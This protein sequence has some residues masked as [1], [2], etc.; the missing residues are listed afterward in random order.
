MRNGDK[1]LSTLLMAKYSPRLVICQPPSPAPIDILSI[2][3]I[4]APDNHRD[5]GNDHT[6]SPSAEFQN[7]QSVAL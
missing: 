1:N 3:W 7:Q 2:V 4:T 5:H 6:V